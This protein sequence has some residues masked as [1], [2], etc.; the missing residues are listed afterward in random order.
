[1]AVLVTG[2]A[3]YIGSHMAHYLADRGEQVVV[4][5]D[6]SRGRIDLVPS[7]A[8]LVRGCA[9]DRKL[10]ADVCR[11]YD[12]DAVIHFAGYIIV[13]ESVQNPLLYY[14]RNTVASRALIEACSEAGVDK[15]IFSSTASV[16]GSPER[17]PIPETATLDPI[18]PYGRSKLMTETMLADADQAYGLRSVVLRYFNVAG[19]DPDLRT[20]QVSLVPTHLIKIASQVALGLRPQLKIFGSD[21][22]TPDGTCVRDYVHVT[23]LVNAHYLALEYLR[24]GGRSRTYNCGYG[25]GY[26]VM[27]VVKTFSAVTGIPL[28]YHYDTRRPGDPPELV[29]DSTALIRDLSWRPRHN[30]L[31]EIIE[32]AFAWE[33]QDSLP[34]GQD[35][36]AEA[37]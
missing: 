3:G 9:G 30:T 6:L 11:T 32:T 2:G 4:L 1:M 13:P 17:T 31:E 24:F 21:Y 36:L 10:V 23:D 25:R 16:Y 7:S 33:K 29:A 22:P 28:P 34:S 14:D 20:G 15:V 8:S 18:S 27:D 26:S 37:V 35:Q 12:V 5:D 19:A